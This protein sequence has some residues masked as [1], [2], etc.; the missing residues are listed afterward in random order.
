[1][2]IMPADPRQSMPEQHMDREHRVP[3][4]AGRFPLLVLRIGCQWP[5]EGIAGA[6]LHY[7]SDFLGL[8]HDPSIPAARCG[9]W[10]AILRQIS[11][12]VKTFGN[13]S[14]LV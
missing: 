5:I 12:Y 10:A 7:G 1:M 4:R 9:F 3:H 11:D 8:S 13:S 6:E 14:T 2:F